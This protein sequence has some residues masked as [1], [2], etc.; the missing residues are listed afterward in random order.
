MM[1]FI[2]MK[3]TFCINKY[4]NCLYNKSVNKSENLYYYNF[5]RPTKPIIDTSIKLENL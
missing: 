3:K 1:I 2:K 4:N 5:F